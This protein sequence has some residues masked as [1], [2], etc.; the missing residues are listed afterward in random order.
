MAYRGLTPT[1]KALTR[2][3]TVR[4][5][6]RPTTALDA[7]VNCALFAAQ[8]MKYK[9]EWDWLL[10]FDRKSGELKSNPD[11]M[12]EPRPLRVYQWRSLKAAFNIL[13]KEVVKTQLC[14]VGVT[15]VTYTCFKR[16]VWIVRKMYAAYARAFFLRMSGADKAAFNKDEAVSAVKEQVYGEFHKF[17]YYHHM[18]EF[19]TEKLCQL[20]G[21]GGII[22]QGERFVAET[23]EDVACQNHGVDDEDST[24]DGCPDVG[25]ESGENGD[26]KDEEWVDPE[27]SGSEAGSLGDLSLKEQEEE[28][29]EDQALQA[30]VVGP[31]RSGR[32]GARAKAAPDSEGMAEHLLVKK[33]RQKKKKQRRQKEMLSEI[34]N[35]AAVGKAEDE[36]SLPATRTKK[37]AKGKTEEQE[38]RRMVKEALH[39]PA[40]SAEEA[41]DV[42]R[43]LLQEALELAKARLYI[44][45]ST[46]ALLFEQ[47]KRGQRGTEGPCWKPDSLEAKIIKCLW[48]V[49]VS[50]AGMY[51]FTDSHH[52]YHQEIGTNTPVSGGA[53]QL[54]EV[55]EEA[56]RHGITCVL[57]PA[58]GANV[59]NDF[60]NICHHDSP[61]Y[62]VIAGDL[63]V[64]APAI[65]Q[66]LLK[67][68]GEDKWD[69]TEESV[70][71]REGDELPV[72][73][74]INISLGYAH[75]SYDTTL[76]QE[77][78]AS[79][80]VMINLW[81]RADNSDPRFFLYKAVGDLAD[82]LTVFMDVQCSD[83]RQKWFDDDHR[84]EV[85][86]AKF[87]KAMGSRVS[88]FEACTIAITKLGRA[89]GFSKSAVL[90]RHFDGPNDHRRNYHITCI[91]WCVVEMADGYVYR[92]AVIF[93][94]R[95]SIGDALEKDRKWLIPADEMLEAYRSLEDVLEYEETH[96]GLLVEATLEVGSA[97][98]V[99]VRKTQSA[100]CPNGNT[101]AMVD[102]ICRLIDEYSL[103]YR[104]VM[105]LCY[106]ACISVSSATFAF[107]LR[108]WRKGKE[109]PLVGDDDGLYK[110]EPNFIKRYKEECTSLGVS[111][112]NV[113]YVRMQV[114]NNPI[115]DETAQEMERA[116]DR[117]TDAVEMAN[118]GASHLEVKEEL[119]ASKIGIGGIMSLAFYTIGVHVGIL[120]TEEAKLQSFKAVI[121]PDSAFGKY[122]MEQ[123][124]QKEQLAQTLK[125]LASTRK[126]YEYVVENGGCKTCKY[127]RP[128]YAGGKQTKYD[129]Y[130]YG[131]YMYHRKLEEA[132]GRAK[133]RL[134]RKKIEETV[135]L[136]HHPPKL[137]K[138]EG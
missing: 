136:F 49:R 37:K 117:F 89:G 129:V 82:K 79:F 130:T 58:R 124:C 32:I 7:M 114:S 59:G 119:K 121:A 11:K 113:Q 15:G 66:M 26:A 86:A 34:M 111:P 83:G 94:S 104:R 116:V 137:V 73:G 122:L 101:S 71:I 27:G 67:Y 21:G 120:H 80:P 25:S 3:V 46:Q 125:R 63:R 24:D 95:K 48:I 22:E 88:R 9:D 6:V 14:P 138:P 132:D 115:Y 18:V 76:P 68:S 69:D 35:P 52:V 30:A 85:G 98:P 16:H 20:R 102:I 12:W 57:V 62:Q 99:V 29:G 4:N 47:P 41:E 133:V 39:A 54:E 112:Y 50:T 36:E 123:E 135:W 96:W 19:Y 45:D 61:E 44:G 75:Y 118:R 55:R 105:E 81:S 65:V 126:E 10:P 84:V 5:L 97:P 72:R 1:E 128:S 70:I 56:D 92:L 107:I 23:T 100:M 28:E 40:G 8:V 2:F 60:L 43:P 103:S 51:A 53:S 106:L 78:K 64:D 74:T 87:R 108:R 31:R 38:R 42:E 131:Q 33:E 127:H 91:W 93:Y 90:A 109:S 77:T 17:K 134:F 13:E 110:G